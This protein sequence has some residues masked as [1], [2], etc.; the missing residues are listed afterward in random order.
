[1]LLLFLQSNAQKTK[2]SYED[3]VKAAQ[4]KINVYL[5]RGKIVDGDT[6]PVVNLREIIVWGAYSF[7]TEEEEKAYRKL[8]R[9]VRRVYPQAI[10]ISSTVKEL[11]I[12]TEGM[13]KRERKK[14]LQ[15]KEDTLRAQ[16]ERAFRTNTVDQAQILI[17][18]IHRE[19]G[20]SAHAIIKDLKGGWSAMKWQT[21]SRLVGTDL[22]DEY[23]PDGEDAKIE[24]IVKQLEEGVIW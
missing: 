16:F 1:M 4:K 13:S 23:H 14:Y 15:T 22:K 7:A 10:V 5:L 6:I 8:V 2:M 18:L 19:T 24:K 3:S 17:K 12:E 21:V 11:Q 9:D 20:Q